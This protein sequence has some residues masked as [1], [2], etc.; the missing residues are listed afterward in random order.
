[1]PSLAVAIS[2]VTR[3]ARATYDRM[4]A[5]G[6][7]VDGILLRVPWIRYGDPRTTSGRV[8]PVDYRAA[9]VFLCLS[10]ELAGQELDD[11]Y[12]EF[13]DRVKRLPA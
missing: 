4:I 3:S 12:Q 9:I 2:D 6:L 1:M 5:H 7:T 11:E 10:S 8:A 13:F